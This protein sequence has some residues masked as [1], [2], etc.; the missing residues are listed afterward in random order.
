MEDAGA[1]EGRGGGVPAPYAS[2]QRRVVDDPCVA[3]YHANFACP[4]ASIFARMPGRK[5]KRWRRGRGGEDRD[6]VAEEG[7]AAPPPRGLAAPSLLPPR[8]SA[9]LPLPRLS[10]RSTELPPPC[11]P[12][13]PAAL[14]ELPLPCRST[15]HPPSCCRRASSLHLACREDKEEGEKCH[16][17]TTSMPYGSQPAT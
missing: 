11:R 2:D 16:V 13:T 1:R 14:A 9:E 8:H 15:E 4:S 6:E 10:R 7:R 5:K 3:S 12:V 17:S